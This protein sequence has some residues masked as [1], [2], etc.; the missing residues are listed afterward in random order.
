MHRIGTPVIQLV[1]FHWWRLVTPV[2]NTRWH[3]G[4]LIVA[5]VGMEEYS[6]VCVHLSDRS[7]LLDDPGG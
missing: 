5:L 3:V 6:A 7:S 1:L 4:Q 2:A